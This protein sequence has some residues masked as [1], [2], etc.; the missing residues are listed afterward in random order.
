MSS[1]E[2]KYIAVAYELY[3]CDE[4]GKHLVEKA[5]VDQPFN[6]VSGFGLTLEDFEK[7]V[8]AL[9]NEQEFDFTLTPEQAYGEYYEDRVISLEKENF[10][11]DGKF[12]HEHI[13][14]G[15]AIPLQN[16]E[17]Q[18]FMGLVLEINEKDVV[19][20]L[21]HPLA[22]KSLNFKGKVVESRLAKE[23]EI[24]HVIKQ[25]SGGCGCGNCGGDGCGGCGGDDCDGENCEGGC[26]GGGCCGH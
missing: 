23:H 1:I 21:N 5:P 12:D 18:R 14:K 8:A 24:T 16:E 4:E 6:F 7:E 11:M 26:G 2:H 3:T 17:G 25:L 13:Q 19:L 22:G 15:T 9:E 20:D 10:E